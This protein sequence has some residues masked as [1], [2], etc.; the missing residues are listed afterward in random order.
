MRLR[1][2]RRRYHCESPRL[3]HFALEHFQQQKGLHSVSSLRSLKLWISGARV[4]TATLKYA[5]QLITALSLRLSTDSSQSATSTNRLRNESLPSSLFRRLSAQLRCR[6]VEMQATCLWLAGCQTSL[7]QSTIW[8]RNSTSRR[9]QPSYLSSI[10]LWRALRLIQETG[11]SSASSQTLRLT[12]LHWDLPSVSTK[13]HTK[14]LQ[15]KNRR[16]FKWMRSLGTK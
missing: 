10:R 5:P 8:K 7:F 12:S 15:R 4:K 13:T 3:F 16:Q 9:H 6:S 11:S 14:R 1:N 2:S